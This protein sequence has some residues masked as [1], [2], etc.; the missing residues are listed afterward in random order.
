MAEPLQIVAASLQ[1]VELFAKIVIR[2]KRL[3][4]Q[5]KDT[6]EYLR[7]QTQSLDDFETS[8]MSCKS[9]LQKNATQ[10]DSNIRPED[11]SLF[12]RLLGRVD[13][14]LSALETILS[15]LQPQSDG[16]RESWLNAIRTVHNG[17]NIDEHI[18]ELSKLRAQIDSFFVRHTFD[19]V[20]SQR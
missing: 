20:A 5:L 6:P 9:I 18:R 14:E 10:I 3:A 17:K 11:V 7:R 8:C 12:K 19:L 4:S 2:T 16:R 13:G 1:I 15:I